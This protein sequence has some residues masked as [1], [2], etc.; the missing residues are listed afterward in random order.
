MALTDDAIHEPGSEL[1]RRC[2][3]VPGQ[4]TAD[5]GAGRNAAAGSPGVAVHT[6][7]RHAVRFDR[8]S[9]DFDDGVK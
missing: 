4:F 8:G 6:T 5:F 1:D 3:R 9:T 2:Y 7:V